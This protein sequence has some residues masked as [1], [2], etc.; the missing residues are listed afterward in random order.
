MSR[1]SYLIYDDRY[2]FNTSYF[3]F[4]T[5]AY[6]AYGGSQ[7]RDQIGAATASLHTPQPQQCGIRVAPVTYTAAFSNTRTL[8]H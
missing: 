4:P 6:V 1:I 3:F 2:S 8:T 7:A 5:A